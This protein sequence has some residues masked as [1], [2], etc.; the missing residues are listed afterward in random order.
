MSL[1][2]DDTAE[3]MAWIICLKLL[4]CFATVIGVHWSL[5]GSID[6][7]LNLYSEGF[8]T[9]VAL[10]IVALKNFQIFFLAF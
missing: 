4:A 9:V 5:E 6:D 10:I 7:W 3:N 8:D 1:V 2:D